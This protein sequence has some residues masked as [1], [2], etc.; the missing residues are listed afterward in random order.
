MGVTVRKKSKSSPEWWVFI[1]HKGKRRS[2]KI[3]PSKKAAEA[4]AETIR[5]N[6]AEKKVGIFQESDKKINFYSYARGWLD[7]YVKQFKSPGTYTR[8]NGLLKQ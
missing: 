2:I 6:L 3:G 8:Y 4:T 5:H 1:H 7:D